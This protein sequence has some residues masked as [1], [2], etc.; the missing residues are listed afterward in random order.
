MNIRFYNAKILNPLENHTFE[1]TEGEVCVKG[2][3]ICSVGSGQAQ[4]GQWE[5]EID[6]CGC[7]IMPGFKN[8]HTHTAMTFLRSYADDL[9][10]QEW[11]DQQVF[12][13]EAQ[14]TQ[15][16]A[17]WLN[18]LGI[19]EYLTSGITADFDMYFLPIPSAEAAR[20]TGFRT[21]QVSG[22]NNFV[23][24]LAQMEEEYYA[25]TQMCDRTSYVAGIHAEYTTSM[26]LMEGAARLAQKLH[27]PFYMHNAETKR[28]VE[29]CIHRWGRTPTALTEELGMYEYGGGGYHCIWLDEA[30]MELFARR[31]LSVVT[32]PAS[33]LK[34]A[35]GIAP[36]KAFV[37][38]GINVAIGTD[39]PASNNCLDMFRETYLTACLAKIREMDA[40]AV[41]AEEVL[42]MATTGGAQAMGLDL[43]SRL[44]PG[45]KADL[46]LLDLHQ[47]NMQPEN[48]IVKNIVYSGC[49][50]NVRLTM[51]DGRILYE[52]G[53]FDIGFEPDEI[54]AKANEIITRMR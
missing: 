6:A 12:P 20:D 22:L 43:C 3:T 42:Y 4:P 40:A 46:I 30:D 29:E 18:I 23:S 19:M 24:S 37:E 14:L 36:V 1:L 39:G 48:N 31:G 54:Y 26:E 51:V 52:D 33:N 15:E 41:A 17:Y 45:Q 2:S 28:E 10:L 35:S 16:D 11:L 7:V 25:I 32:N 38:R 49:K 53:R 13:K 34:L 27:L 9:P 8:A 50:Q 47:P 21:V 44:E 5:R